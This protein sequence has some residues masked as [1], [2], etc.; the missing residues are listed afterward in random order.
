MI[1]FVAFFIRALTGFGAG[2]IA[3]PL[4]AMIWDLKFVVPMQLLFEVA[5]SLIL[6]PK[7]HR[8]IDYGQAGPVAV[9]L[10]VGNVAGAFALAFLAN[11]IL[12]NALAGVVLFFAVY[13]GATVKRPP[14]WKI[15]TRWGGAFGLVG[16]VFGGTFGMSGPLVVLYL[17]HQ[18]ASKTVLRATLI[19]LFFLAS[20]WTALV[21]WYNGLYGL[22]TFRVL[23]FLVPPFLLGTYLGHWAHSRTSELLFRIIIAV[24]LLVS[25][26]LLAFGG[27]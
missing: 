17:A 21:H 1:I 27:T 4:L 5:I 8:D 18:I 3:I 9:G 22:E 15:P 10:F 23:A 25:G 26:L 12:K 20:S 19:G 24:I 13:L 2:L 11:D 7:V 16:G 6:L 14:A